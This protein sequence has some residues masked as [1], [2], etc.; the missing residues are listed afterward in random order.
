MEELTV[1]VEATL[2]LTWEGGP[3]VVRVP[4]NA[5]CGEIEVAIARNL[6]LNVM[7]WHWDLDKPEIHDWEVVK[8][9]DAE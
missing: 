5:S 8:N 3:V 2:L 6:R 4:S 7:G 1:E 9:E